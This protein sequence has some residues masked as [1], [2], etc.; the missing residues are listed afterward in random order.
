MAG[1]RLLVNNLERRWP[2]GVG[3]EMTYGGR[4]TNLEAYH[5]NGKNESCDGGLN[6]FGWR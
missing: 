3:S 4:I 5:R 6:L 1:V 2:R